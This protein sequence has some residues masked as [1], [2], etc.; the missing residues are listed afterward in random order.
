MQCGEKNSGGHAPSGC[1]HWRHAATMAAHLHQALS[2]EQRHREIARGRKARRAARLR[3]KRPVAAAPNGLVSRVTSFADVARLAAE[4]RLA[5]A[6]PRIRD[7]CRLAPVAAEIAQVVGMDQ[8]KD[9]LFRA[10]IAELFEKAHPGPAR[11]MRNILISGPPGVGKTMLAGL[12]A[13]LYAAIGRIATSKVV[14]AG[15]ADLVGQYLGH[16]APQTRAL[17]QS[18]RGGVLFI[19]EIYALGNGDRDAFGDE[20]IHQL[21]ECISAE[22]GTLFIIAGYEAAIERQFLARN[23]G[24]RRR[25]PVVIRLSPYTPTQL[26]AIVGRMVAT[27]G[28][29]ADDDALATLSNR[30]RTLADQGAACSCLVANAISTASIRLWKEGVGERRISCTDMAAALLATE[31]MVPVAD[32][33]VL[34]AMYS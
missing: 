26:A 33:D 25:F 30:E 32:K 11:P 13:K 29:A 15:R 10:A 6:D 2:R 7:L 24:L 23:P 21:T 9:V 22:T 8:A 14:V 3:A 16:T 1:I 17:V 31:R 5:G 34:S 28:W 20:A 27:A 18:A 4:S 12:I 19:D